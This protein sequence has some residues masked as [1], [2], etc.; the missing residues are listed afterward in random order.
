MSA[1]GHENAS[2]ALSGGETLLVISFSTLYLTDS[3]YGIHI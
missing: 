1:F 2:N 3:S